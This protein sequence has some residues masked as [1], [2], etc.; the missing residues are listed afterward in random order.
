MASVT[1]AGSWSTANGTNDDRVMV[2][3]TLGLFVVADAS[4]PTYGGYHAPFGVDPGLAALRETF[5]CDDG[6]PAERLQRAM[7]AAHGAMYARE[8]RFQ[9]ELKRHGTGKGLEAAFAATQAVRE[10]GHPWQN[11]FA[12]FA[13]WVTAL[14]LDEGV[15]LA[16][17]GACRAYR[18]REGKLELLCP[19]HTF[20]TL[21]PAEF[22]KGG[23]AEYHGD[24][25]TRMLGLPETIEIDGWH[26]QVRA[27]D[28]YVLCSDGVWA[29]VGDDRMA[30]LLKRTLDCE[31]AAQ[32]LA[33]AAQAGEHAD[34][35]TA[36]VVRVG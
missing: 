16:Q 13:A 6:P 27:G 33:S 25:V 14:H 29:T 15:H 31:A 22:G 10:P 35:A 2:D 23:P 18:L 26:G 21:D 5:T 34:D 17:V 20:A 3:Q 1:A 11:T 19:D 12:H 32:A 4:G 24:V 30:K 36:I 9:A 8:L 28:M 7:L